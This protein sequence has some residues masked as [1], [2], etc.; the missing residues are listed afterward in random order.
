M[1]ENDRP[2]LPQAVSGSNTEMTLNI[3]ENAVA[4]SASLVDVTRAQGETQALRRSVRFVHSHVAPPHP[5]IVP[6]VVVLI[7]VVDSQ[8]DLSLLPSHDCVLSFV[9]L[10]GAGQTAS[11]RLHM[12]TERSSRVQ[13]FF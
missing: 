4:Q 9:R 11:L 12:D 7:S 6:K 5:P 3:R 2:A 8:S 1:R 13:F 10:R